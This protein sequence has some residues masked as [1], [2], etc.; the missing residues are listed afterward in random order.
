MPGEAGSVDV[1]VALA[2]RLVNGTV[3]DVCGGVLRTVTYSRVNPRHRISAWVRL[4]ALTAAHPGREFEAVTI[5]RGS[6]GIAIARIEPL[7]AGSAREQLAVVLDLFE[8]GMREPLPLYCATS[9]AWA[10]AR[11][12]GADPAKAAEAAWK[13]P[14]NFAKEDREPEH[15]LVLGGVKTLDDLIAEP[16]RDGEAWVLDEPGRLGRYA[17]RLWDG[18]LERERVTGA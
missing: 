2:G 7:D 6:E 11:R 1:R 17:R 14:W 9:A 16:P 8:R 13:S 3:P 12:T 15:T 4:L 18:L 5:G 10:E